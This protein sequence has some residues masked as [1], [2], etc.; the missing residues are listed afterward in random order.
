MNITLTQLNVLRHMD[1]DATLKSYLFPLP[2][3]PWLDM[4][5]GEHRRMRLATAAALQRK[6]LITHDLRRRKRHSLLVVWR[7]TDLGR[8]EARK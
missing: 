8:K 4:G 2:T 1:T 3:E 6:G 7:L 5:N